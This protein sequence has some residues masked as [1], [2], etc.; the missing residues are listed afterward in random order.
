VKTVFAPGD[1]Y[2]NPTSARQLREYYTRALPAGQ[3]SQGLLAAAQNSAALSTLNAATGQVVRTFDNSSDTNLG[4]QT[5][6]VVAQAP[7]YKSGSD[8]SLAQVASGLGNTQNVIKGDQPF[9]SGLIQVTDGLFTVPKQ[10]SDTAAANGQTDFNSLVTK[11]GLTSSLDSTPQSTFF[12]PNNAALSAAGLADT[13]AT[14]AGQAASVVNTHVVT[15]VAGYAPTLQNGDKLTSASGDTLSVAVA[16]NGAISVN[17]VPVVQTNLILPNGVAHVLGGVIQSSSKSGGGAPAPPPSGGA[18]S[19]PPPPPS[20]GSSSSAG[21]V[22]GP[23]P[24]S[25]SS[26]AVSTTQAAG[27]VGRPGPSTTTSGPAVVKPTS[28]E[29]A[30][31]P[32]STAGSSVVDVAWRLLVS[33]GAVAG[34]FMAI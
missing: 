32:V 25:S 19:P 16:Q 29:S 11:A 8:T 21:A 31:V 14:S 3:L 13:A 7:A 34:I 30:P 18:P 33:L 4:G 28:T 27:A 17:G 2:F 6:A 22:A 1:A 15:G 12:I 23:G 24:N 26:K 20:G 9:S 5:Q 10:L